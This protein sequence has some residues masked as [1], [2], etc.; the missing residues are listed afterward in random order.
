MATDPANY[1]SVLDGDTSADNGPNGTADLT[2]PNTNDNV[3]PVS[4]AGG[5]TDADNNFVDETGSSTI[6]GTVWED[7]TENNQLDKDAG[8]SGVIISLE[9]AFGNVIAT[10]TTGPGGTYS[11]TNV[12]PGDYFIVIGSTT[13]T[14]QYDNDDTNDGSND[15]EENNTGSATTTTGFVTSDGR[16][17]V[18]VTV[19]GSEIDA[20]NDFI[21]SSFANNNAP[22]PV[23]L[24]SFT[25]REMANSVMLEWRTSFESF[26]EGFEIY[27]SV[28]SKKFTKIGFVKGINSKEASGYEFEHINPVYGENYY[29]LVQLDFDQTKTKSKIVFVSYFNPNSDFINYPNPTSSEVKLKGLRKHDIVTL[30]DISGRLLNRIEV[31]TENEIELLSLEKYQNGVYVIKIARNGLTVY[32]SKIIK[33]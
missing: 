19:T 1:F 33:E 12:P 20:S 6:S 18:S 23:K 17:P 27:H 9:D 14:L 21:T 32:S 8:V 28:D 11:F 2:N 25:A 3:I 24:V 30:S 5:E 26:N 13:K 16:I 31:K 22:L 10:Q 29:Q 4:L 15:T 7:N